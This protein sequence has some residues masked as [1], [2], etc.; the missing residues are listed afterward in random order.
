MRLEEEQEHLRF[1]G[2]EI[3]AVEGVGKA[4]VRIKRT[5]HHISARPLELCARRKVLRGPKA[6]QQPAR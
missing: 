5:D 2:L 4:R 3:H 6:H 1:S